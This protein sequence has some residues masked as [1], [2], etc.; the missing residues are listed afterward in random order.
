M[1][2]EKPGAICDALDSSFS[3]DPRLT[4]VMLPFSSEQKNVAHCELTSQPV[5]CT[6]TFPGSTEVIRSEGPSTLSV[7]APVSA[8]GSTSPARP[9]DAQKISQGGASEPPS[10]HVPGAQAS[11]FSADDLWHRLLKCILNS[12]THF[13]SFLPRHCDVSCR[14]PSCKHFWPLPLS[15]ESGRV[16]CAAELADLEP[17]PLAV[18]LMSSS[19]SFLHAGSPGGKS[20]PLSRLQGRAGTVLL[21]FRRCRF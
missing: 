21:D 11:S 4:D 10:L 8:S 17:Q 5:S 1:R 2:S 15:A 9:Q 6:R 3:F 7:E 19:L 14:R 20:L 18:A 12:G 16:S 13:A